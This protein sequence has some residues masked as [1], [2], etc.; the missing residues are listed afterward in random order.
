MS[1]K[2]LAVV[3]LLSIHH[4]CSTWKMFWEE[5][6]IGEEKF[7]LGEFSAA[8]MKN[9]GRCK[10]RKHR[11]I[12]GSDKDVTCLSLSVGL[13]FESHSLLI[14]GWWSSLPRALAN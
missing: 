8:N 5:K 2:L 14:L 3:T 12:K 9:C 10:V 1:T 7:T 13:V 4:G 11:Y 6:F